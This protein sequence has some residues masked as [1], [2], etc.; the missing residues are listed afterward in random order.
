MKDIFLRLLMAAVLTLAAL[1]VSSTHGPQADEDATSGKSTVQEKI[2]AFGI[3]APSRTSP[4]A[5]QTEDELTFN[6]HIEHENGVLVLK[7][8]AT[9]LTYKLDDQARAAK[10]VG[11]H[12]KVLGRLDMKSNTIQ[13]SNIELVP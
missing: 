11:K 13:V 5:D 8:P 12:V 1:A 10:Y 7:D 2:P 3:Q 6:G 4:R 9:N